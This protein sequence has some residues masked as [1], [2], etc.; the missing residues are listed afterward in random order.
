VSLIQKH[1]QVCLRDGLIETT[2]TN[3]PYVLYVFL[4]TGSPS[5]PFTMRRRSSLITTSAAGASAS[6]LGM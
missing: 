1:I 4:N 2:A 3:Q 5:Q 6:T